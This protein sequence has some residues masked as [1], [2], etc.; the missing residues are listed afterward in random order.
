MCGIV[1]FISNTK[2]TNAQLPKY[3]RQALI[4]DMLRGM[5]S[6]GVFYLPKYCKEGDQAGFLKSCNHGLDFVS[7]KDYDKLETNFGNMRFVVGHNRYAT[8]GAIDVVD[9]AH[10]FQEGQDEKSLVT[11]VHNG[12]LKGIGKLKKTQHSLG[13]DVDSHAICH[14]MALYDSKEVLECLDG[15]YCLVWHDARDN[16]LNF[17][18]NR[19][20]PMWFYKPDTADYILFASEPKMIELIV[21]RTY[22]SNK[23]EYYALPVGEHY[24]FVGNTLKP[25]IQKFK[26]YV[27]T[28]SGR[29]FNNGGYGATDSY[30]DRM[31]SRPAGRAGAAGGA[32]AAA[33]KPFPNALKEQLA[34]YH[35]TPGDRLPFTPMVLNGSIMTGHL[36]THNMAAIGFG[37]SK[38]AME[39]YSDTRW[40]CTPVA[41]TYLPDNKGKDIPVVMC[42]ILSL[43]WNDNMYH[44]A[45]F[46]KRKDDA[47]PEDLPNRRARQGSRV[48]GP[49]NTYVSVARWYDITAHGCF[50]CGSKP[51]IEQADHIVW[52]QPQGTTKDEFACAYCID[53]LTSP[54]KD[55]LPFFGRRVNEV[56]GEEYE[57]TTGAT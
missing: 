28:Y 37:V 30:Y 50:E 15:S 39:A 14:N 43:K 9:N 55:D 33:K 4:V 34:E 25:D 47:P 56:L 46:D 31:W 54:D 2:H 10:P 32:H 27:W 23:G 41:V 11:M 45:G 6:T 12:T 48:K 17:A 8:Q 52:W 29:T 49:G 24:K 38:S 51:A 42:K 35:L 1:G 7:T 13:V 18:R 53:Q 19:E 5:H 16:S 36:D 22:I 44:F 26:P 3:L 57:N 40:Q 20:R 21:E